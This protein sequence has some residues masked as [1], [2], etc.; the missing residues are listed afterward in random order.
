MLGDSS[1]FTRSDEV[2]AAWSL[3]T[4]IL[5]AWQTEAG[6]NLAIYAAGTWGPQEA[7][8]LIARDGRR[9]RKP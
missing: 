5:Q 3:F 7:E 8:E 1:L 2:D 9:W 4:P 6:K